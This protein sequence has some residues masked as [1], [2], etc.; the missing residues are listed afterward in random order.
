[1]TVAGWQAPNTGTQHKA[2]QKNLQKGV[3]NK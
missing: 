1:M 2:Q 3:K